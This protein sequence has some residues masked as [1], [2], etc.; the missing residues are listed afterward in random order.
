MAS[1]FVPVSV[2]GS[3]PASGEAL[4]LLPR[5]PVALGRVEVGEPAVALG[6]HTLEHRVDVAADEDRR[7]GPLDRPGTHHRV[8][9]VELVRLEGHAVLRP[10]SRQD[11]E[12]PLEEPAA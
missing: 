10:E 6:R 3:R 12:V 7:A 11:L 9:Q 8:T 5:L 2:L 4:D 1:W